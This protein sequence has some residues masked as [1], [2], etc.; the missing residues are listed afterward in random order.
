[1][2]TACPAL[3]FETGSHYAAQTFL[4]LAILLSCS[5]LPSAGIVGMYY[6]TV[7]CF[8]FRLV[9]RYLCD[10]GRDGEI[11]ER[12]A[13]TGPGLW[14]LIDRSQGAS[15]SYLAPPPLLR[16]LGRGGNRTW[17][18]ESHLTFVIRGSLELTIQLQLRPC[19][20]LTI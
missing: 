11:V 8:N 20:L 6:C 17:Q 2:C 13:N 15:S 4:E 9:G 18:G 1:M 3:S 7:V 14:I 10:E 19:F 12:V 5:C 16:A